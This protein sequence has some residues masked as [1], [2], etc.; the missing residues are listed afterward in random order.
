MRFPMVQ[1]CSFGAVLVATRKWKEVLR[2]QCHDFQC[3]L[4][5]FTLGFVY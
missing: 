4:Q 1:F 3:S 2:L 5:P